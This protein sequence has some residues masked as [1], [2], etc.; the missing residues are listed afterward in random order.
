MANGSDFRSH[1]EEAVK[2]LSLS[3]CDFRLVSLHDYERILVAILDRFTTLGKKGFNYSGWWGSFK[4]QHS[5]VYPADAPAALRELVSPQETVW[6]VAENKGSAKQHGNFWLY[7]GKVAAVV[8]VIEEMYAF[9]YYI[10][11]KKFEWL[12]GEDHHGVL[13][14]V[15]QPITEKIERL[16]SIHKNAT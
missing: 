12:L 10:V 1:V 16:K 4:E 13:V 14:G 15:G 9:E 8:K 11:S 3:D 7:E 5:S 2:A 6:F